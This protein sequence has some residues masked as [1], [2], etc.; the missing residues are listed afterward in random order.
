MD[1]YFDK[2]SSKNYILYCG[3]GFLKSYDYYKGKLFKDYV[4]SK[5]NNANNTYYHFVIYDNGIKVKLIT[6]YS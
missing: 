6:T 4:K 2:H 5:E 3:I 1:I